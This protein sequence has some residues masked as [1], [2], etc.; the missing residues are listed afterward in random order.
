VRTR[1]ALVLFALVL[2]LTGCSSESGG[3]AYRSGTVAAA[4]KKRGFNVHVM[5]DRSRGQAS[6]G[7]TLGL[8]NLSDV[9]GVDALVA[10]A[11]LNGAI[12][13]EI[14]AWI[15]DTT[16]HADSFRAD[17]ASSLQRNNVVILVRRRGQAA[18][19]AAL[20]DLG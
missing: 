15:F 14:S 17:N 9:D 2:T 13:S 7:P 11:G 4:L 6:D 18:A 1:S 12:G 20:D 5:F 16:D 8:L 19:K 10:D 3:A